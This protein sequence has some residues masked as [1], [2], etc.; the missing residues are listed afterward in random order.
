MMAGYITFLSSTTQ[1]YSATLEKLVT[2]RW[3]H[4]THHTSTSKVSLARYSVTP[5]LLM[6]KSI[7]Y[8]NYKSLFLA[9]LGYPVKSD[10]SQYPFHVLVSDSHETGTSHRTPQAKS[11]KP[12]CTSFEG[13]H[14]LLQFK[15]EEE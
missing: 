7:W 10:P 1:E 5:I 6:T 9:T 11:S 2:N 8:M 14:L 4:Y 13:S 15:E 3:L 12:S